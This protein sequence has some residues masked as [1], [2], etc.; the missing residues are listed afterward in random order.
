MEK[1]KN[2]GWQKNCLQ[3]DRV[4]DVIS[5]EYSPGSKDV[6]ALTAIQRSEWAAVRNKYFTSGV[7]KDS[8]SVIETAAFHVRK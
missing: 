2:T 4:S 7:N 6:A 8:I 5:D 1:N 3:Y